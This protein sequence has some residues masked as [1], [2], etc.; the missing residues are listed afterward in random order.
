[1]RETQSY[2]AAQDPRRGLRKLPQRTEK[3]PQKGRKKKKTH[4][5]G[6]EWLTLVQSICFYF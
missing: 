3:G 5:Q 6:R 1:M 4:Q 2:K